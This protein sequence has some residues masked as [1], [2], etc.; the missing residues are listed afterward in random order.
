MKCPLCKGKK[1]IPTRHIH[2]GDGV[3]KEEKCPC[4]HGDG[5]VDEISTSKSQIVI[6]KYHGVYCEQARD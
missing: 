2:F 3:Y 6:H 1:T 4:C 5:E